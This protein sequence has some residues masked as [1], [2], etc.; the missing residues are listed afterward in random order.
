MRALA[1]QHLDIFLTGPRQSG[2]TTLT[3]ATFPEFKYVS[4]EDL[5]NRQEASENPPLRGPI[6]ENLIVN[7]PR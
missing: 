6:F 1:T 7:E 3:M 5:R 4:L 2:K